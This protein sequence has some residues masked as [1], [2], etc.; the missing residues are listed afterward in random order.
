MKK[1]VVDFSYDAAMRSV[2]ESL[3]RMG[4]DRVDIVYIHDPFNEQ[5]YHAAMR[6]AYLALHKLRS[7]KVVHAIG[8]GIGM[9]DK[10]IR[11]A[12]DGDFDCFLVA[13]RYTH[14]AV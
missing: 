12:H 5:S 2:E 3:E 4:M 11:F 7:E 9:N 13:G 10:L 1:I 6:G 14:E 8:V